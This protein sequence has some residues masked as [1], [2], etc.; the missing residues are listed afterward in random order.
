MIYLH[1]LFVLT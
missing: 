1:M